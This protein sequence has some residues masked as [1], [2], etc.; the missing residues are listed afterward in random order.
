MKS[1][2]P[3]YPYLAWMLV[4]IVAPLLLVFTFAFTASGGGFTLANFS[5]MLNYTTIFARSFEL[6]I[7]ATV[8]CLLIG[9]PVAM[10]LSRLGGTKQALCLMLIILPMWMNFLL[11]TYAW[12][13]ILENN[14]FLNQLLGRLGLA[15]VSVINTPYAVLIGMVYNFLPFMILPIYTVMTK[16][17]D[18]LIEAAQDLGASPFAVFR[19]VTF[20]LSIPGVLSG[21]TMVFVPGVSTFIISSMLGGG[22]SMMVGDLIEKQFVG[23]S[24][25]PNLGSAIALVMML[26][27][28]LFMVLMNR[29]DNEESGVMMK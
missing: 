25:N 8:L 2:L 29:A 26:L 20:P 23:V 13:S 11:R 27:I 19:R 10:I 22:K 15:P 5:Q 18:H 21:V 12:M 3:A 4:F 6:S 28:F 24:Y 9:Y 1:K 14:G 17:D 16:L 7:A